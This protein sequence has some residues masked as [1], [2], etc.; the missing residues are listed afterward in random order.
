MGPAPLEHVLDPRLF[1]EA[2]LV[3]ELDLD[4][5][6]LG[7]LLGVVSHL[8]TERLGEAWVVEDADVARVQVRGHAASV[9]KTRQR[10]LQD[11]PVPARQHP[12]DLAVVAIVQGAHPRRWFR[13]ADRA[14]ARSP[15]GQPRCVIS[16]N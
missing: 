9:R 4:A 16:G 11:H 13:A 8:V 5:G 10:P 15:E 1:A 7:E 6:L 14:T 2:A 12:R 3:H